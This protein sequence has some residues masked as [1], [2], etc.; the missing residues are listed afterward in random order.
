MVNA[1]QKNLKDCLE[2][3]CYALAFY[4]ETYTS[5]FIFNCTFHDSI[6]TDEETERNQDRIDM[7]N[8]IMSRIE[9]RMKWYNEDEETA[10]KNMPQI[11]TD[12]QE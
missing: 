4:N 2:D 10:M 8:G 12:V 5:D 1:M 6:L 3:L 7:S 11:E 9:Y